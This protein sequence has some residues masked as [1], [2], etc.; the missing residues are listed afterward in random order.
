MG[1]VRITSQRE[2]WRSLAIFAGMLLSASG[3]APAARAQP[4]TQPIPAQV[5]LGPAQYGAGYIPQ[6]TAAPEDVAPLAPIPSFPT[7]GAFGGGPAFAPSGGAPSG[8]VQDTTYP[9]AQPYGR[10]PASQQ[11]PPSYPMPG[12]DWSSGSDILPADQSQPVL[13]DPATG[14]ETVVECSPEAPIKLWKGNFE[15]GLNGSNGNSDT[16]SFRFGSHIERCCDD[17][18]LKLDGT[19][20]KSEDNQQETANRFFGE[21]RHEWFLAHPRWSIYVHGTMEY[22]EFRNFDLRLTGDAGIAYY[23]I[24]NDVAQW[25]G[26]IGPGVSHE[27]GSPDESYVPELVLGSTAEYKLT[28]KQTLKFNSDYYPDI[29]DFSE[30]RINSKASWD[31][32]LDE[33]T[34]L[35][36]SLGVLNR[37]DSTP[38]GAEPN[39]FDYFATVLWS[40]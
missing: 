22:D 15:M 6:P 12:A 37:Y 36:L 39:D 1:S 17:K 33:V 23:F 10:V 20:R 29:S 26:R 32:L 27:L 9:A 5:A 16:F 30:Y 21:A 35:S 8:P 7:G 38:N 24:K 4:Q 40:F 18:T 2:A 19:Y 31:I 13:V 28:K 25:Q 34:N 3:F 14:E 11:M